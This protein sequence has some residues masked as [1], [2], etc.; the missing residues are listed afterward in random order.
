ML[1]RTAGSF[2]VL[3]AGDFVADTFFAP[4]KDAL[5]LRK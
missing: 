5:R 4:Q 2:N 3:I 1:E